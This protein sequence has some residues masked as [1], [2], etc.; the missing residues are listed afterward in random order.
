MQKLIDDLVKHFALN[1]E[2]ER[3]F[4]IV[5]NHAVGPKTEQLTMYIGG[6]GGTGKTQVIKT[7]IQLFTQRNESH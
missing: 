2:Q 4:R 3:A 6:L 5:A 7:L 1:P